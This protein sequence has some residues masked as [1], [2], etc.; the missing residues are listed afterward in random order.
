MQK[1]VTDDY[2]QTTD[3]VSRPMALIF[4]LLIVFVVG[5]VA[6]SLFLGGRWL[7][8]NLDGSNAPKVQVVENPITVTTP[9]AAST[10]SNTTS[11]SSGSTSSA[12][13]T[14]PSTTTS[15][16]ASTSSTATQTATSTPTTGPSTTAESIPATGPTEV[17]GVFIVTML[18][19]TFAHNVWL[20]K[21]SY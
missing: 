8:Q 1:N 4:T 3:T 15:T 17:L 7:F 12:S 10:S 11:N 18:L 2:L 16:A 20:R 6:F 19:A 14:K 13:Q 21:K 5:A 9:S